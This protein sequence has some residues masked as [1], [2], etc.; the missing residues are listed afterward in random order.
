MISIQYLRAAAAFAVV[1]FHIQPRIDKLGYSG[2]WPD[3]L[4][5]GVDLFFVISGF[6]MV[7][8]NRDGQKT[9]LEFAID[10]V[11]RIVPIYWI[12]TTA[13]VLL[14]GAFNWHSLASYFFVPW[15]HPTEDRL[16]PILIPGWTLNY[17]MFFYAVF[18]GS[19]AVSSRYFVSV[20]L[21]LLLLLCALNP[22]L[23]TPVWKFYTDAIILEFGMGMII[24]AAWQQGK[25]RAHWVLMPVG[26]ALMP[27]L[28]FFNL[29]RVI[30]LGIP[31]A[32]VVIGAIASEG[33][34][35]IIRP[36]VILGDASY[37]LYLV[38]GLALSFTFTA[39]KQFGVS[40]FAFVPL[41]MASA[42]LGGLLA[43]Y[44]VEKPIGRA[45]NHWSKAI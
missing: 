38:H 12:W 25:L 16:F 14:S 45:L 35:T 31:S 22:V 32:L 8:T 4:K 44:F 11:R 34:I 43:F 33:R 30:A 24:A 27:F 9:A 23:D 1:V 2:D 18:A 15:Q 40:W 41:A 39:A 36:L 42:I 26:L 29:H 5:G 17:E 3:W 21:A 19:L 20:C 7:A 6:I 10:R 13:I 28:E 37:S